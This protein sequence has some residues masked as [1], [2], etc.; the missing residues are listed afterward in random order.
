MK[1]NLFV[2]TLRNFAWTSICRREKTAVTL[3]PRIILWATHFLSLLRCLPNCFPQ[4]LLSGR[5]ASYNRIL[6]LRIG[7]KEFRTQVKIPK[8]GPPLTRIQ[9]LFFA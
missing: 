1:T 3:A 8:R 7:R 9:V 2:G 5:N 6:R 4:D